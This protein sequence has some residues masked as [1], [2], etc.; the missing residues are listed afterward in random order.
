MSEKPAMKRIMIID[1][2]EAFLEELTDLLDSAGYKTI[3]ISKSSYALLEVCKQKPDVI[4][5]DLKMDI[6]DGFTIAN[7]LSQIPETSNIPIIGITGIYTEKSHRK[8]MEEVG[9][10]RCLTKPINPSDII[11]L[12]GKY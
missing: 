6:V 7:D 11:N 3:P 1:D 8:L 12:L 9:I 5:L 2:D 4:L 10:N